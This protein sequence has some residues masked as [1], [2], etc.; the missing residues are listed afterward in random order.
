MQGF[1]GE[2]W[3]PP[4]STAAATAHNNNTTAD[5]DIE[6]GLSR[7]LSLGASYYERLCHDEFVGKRMSSAREV[8]IHLLT[9]MRHLAIS[10][11][12]DK[13]LYLENKLTGCGHLNE[14]ELESL[15]LLLRRQG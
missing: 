2:W 14:E 1:T 13:L 9:H 12:N 7:P 4:S 8:K 5:V 10:S 6:L 15:V 11:V 3:M